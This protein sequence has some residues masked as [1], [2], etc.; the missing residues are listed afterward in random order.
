MGV[1][2]DVWH[3]VDDQRPSAMIISAWRHSYDG[4]RA[5]LASKGFELIT[6]PAEFAELLPPRDAKG[7]KCFMQR[8]VVVG[9]RLGP[10]KICALLGAGAR[11]HFR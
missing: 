2:N 9:E 10:T 3:S 5:A 6:T 1:Q 8:K 7:A 11:I 4:V